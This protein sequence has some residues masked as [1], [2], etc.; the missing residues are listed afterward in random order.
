MITLRP[1]QPSIETLRA[2]AASGSSGVAR[3]AQAQLRQATING[4]RKAVQS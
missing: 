2:L 4:L 3:R 1:P